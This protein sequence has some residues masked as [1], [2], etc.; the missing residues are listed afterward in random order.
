[1]SHKLKEVVQLVLKY[2]SESQL[3]MDAVFQLL[4]YLPLS[5]PNN[6]IGPMSLRLTSCSG[7]T[8]TEENGAVLDCLCALHS[9]E[10]VLTAI[11]EWLQQG[12][13][14]SKN[15]IAQKP[16]S[17]KP[18]VPA[19][20]AASSKSENAADVIAQLVDDG[21]VS[22]RGR[23]AVCIDLIKACAKILLIFFSI[24]CFCF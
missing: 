20:K 22:S 8:L 17:K 7:D 19:R 6:I 1:L 11:D 5:A 4:R 12:L 9:T 15:R 23:L 16:Q 3:E 13:A 10:L 18:K 24:F 2:S 21:D 14:S